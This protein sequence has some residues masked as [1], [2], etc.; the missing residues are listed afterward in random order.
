[1][2]DESPQRM[3]VSGSA[4]GTTKR[5]IEKKVAAGFAI[6][7]AGLERGWV[8]KDLKLTLHP[9]QSEKLC[10]HIEAAWDGEEALVLGRD[11]SQWNS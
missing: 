3:A 2:T 5:W 10:N 11:L 4:A 1:M 6:A 8:P 9:L 7:L